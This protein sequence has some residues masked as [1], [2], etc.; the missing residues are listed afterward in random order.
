MSQCYADGMNS[1]TYIL[2]TGISIVDQVPDSFYGMWRVT[3]RLADTSSPQTFK[4][5]SVDLWN[6]SRA[7]DVINLSNP[8]TGASASITVSSVNNNIIR[9]SKTGNYDNKRLT[10]TVEIK[11]D[12]ERFT[13]V[14][15]FTLE[16]LSGGVVIKK[17]TAV[18]HLK[19]ERISGSAQAGNLGLCYYR[20]K[21]G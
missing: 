13:G 4:P 5:T 11:L 20:R 17:E 6:L 16:T 9:F 12:G 1:E 19:G 18:Y 2:K 14:N 10:D 3:A 15:G 8:F 7:G 21:K